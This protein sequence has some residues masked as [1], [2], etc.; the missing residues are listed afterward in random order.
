M[1]SP[2]LICVYPL[3]PTYLPLHRFLYYISIMISVLYPTPPPLVKGAFAFSLTY[4]STA[5]LYVFLIAGIHQYQTVNLDIFGLW[6]ILSSAAIT[7]LPLLLWAKNLKGAGSASARPIIRIW[8]V[9]VIAATICIYVLLIKW[10]LAVDHSEGQNSNNGFCRE[11]AVRSGSKIHLR[12][13]EDVLVAE[14]DPVFGQIYNWIIQRVSG[15]VFFPAAFGL[16]TSFV[17]VVHDPPIYKEDL[18]GLGDFPAATTEPTSFSALQ[19]C[20]AH[21]RKLVLCLTPLF[22]V[23]TMVIN[24]LYLLKDRGTGLLEGERIYEVGQWGIW[25]G[26]GLVGAAALVNS[27]V[28]KPK[29]PKTKVLFGKSTADV[30]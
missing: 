14:Y 7:V 23:A 10:R 18:T 21:L 20:Y 27:V 19:N 22:L 11:L 26:A 16:I 1:T 3:S 12:N 17:T 8:G 30:V 6:A 15:L 25:A 13:P 29:K 28:A 4:S 24:E 5:A 2:T 9:L